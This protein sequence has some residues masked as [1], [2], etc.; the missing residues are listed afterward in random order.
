MP[1]E[2]KIGPGRKQVSAV[3]QVGRSLYALLPQ[4]V[5][6]EAGLKRGDRMV[7]ETDGRLIYAARI[8]FEE[9]ISRRKVL[10]PVE[11]K[12]K[13]IQAEDAPASR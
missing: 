12:P 8:P 5:C 6:Q 7:I 9:L 3:V 4:K 10:K 13:A 11:L 1:H 2:I